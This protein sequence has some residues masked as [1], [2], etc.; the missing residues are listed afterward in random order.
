MADRIHLVQKPQ[1]TPYLN[2]KVKSENSKELFDLIRTGRTKSTGDDN[3]NK[4][5][6][7]KIDQIKDQK[8]LTKNTD[9]LINALKLLF[10]PKDIEKIT[11]EVFQN[12][13][14][15]SKSLLAQLNSQ[16]ENASF[17]KGELFDSLRLALK[18][19]IRDPE[20][21][22]ATADFL[23]Q[24]AHHVMKGKANFTEINKALEKII[25][26]LEE[27]PGN[28]ELASKLKIQSQAINQ[29]LLAQTFQ[30]N[31][32]LQGN[33][34]DQILTALLKK[35]EE[36]P[37]KESIKNM[38]EQV[39]RGLLVTNSVNQPILHFV[40][41]LVFND[42]NSIIEMWIDP[43]A[44]SEQENNLLNKKQ[45]KVFLNIDLDTLGKLELDLLLIENRI[46]VKLFCEEENFN[47]F[48]EEEKY[49]AEVVQNGSFSLGSVEILPLL[50]ERTLEEVFNK[51]FERRMAIDAKV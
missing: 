5:D 29:A 39:L 4:I 28:S 37:Q 51:P 8:I 18:K 43:N 45:V 50:S 36:N 33:A 46:D 49:I 12:T 27:L 32:E 26:R 7:N 15:D 1:N 17:F 19:N 2:Q 6:P 25:Q 13:N 20:L 30:K 21:K 11:K 34:I 9:P 42:I 38:G 22:G 47:L 40:L 44:K 10:S 31:V 23:K 24:Y 41:P 48:A 16:K 3:K 14:I 35:I